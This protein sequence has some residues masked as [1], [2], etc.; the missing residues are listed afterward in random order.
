[1]KPKPKTFKRWMLFCEG[2]PTSTI[3]ATRR[4][5]EDISFDDRIDT[6]ERV[7]IR[8]IERKGRSKR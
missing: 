3:R 4:D 6:V 8:V 2:K 1:M 7:E 5:I